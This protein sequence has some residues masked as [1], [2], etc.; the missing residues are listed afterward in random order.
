MKKKKIILDDILALNKD[1]IMNLINDYYDYHGYDNHIYYLD[2]F[3]EVLA[4]QPPIYI[5]LMIHKGSFTPT[6]EYFTFDGYGNIESVYPSI[7]LCKRI[8]T[9]E[10]LEFINNNIKEYKQ[11]F[12]TIKN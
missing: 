10:F 12:K 6:C 8:D 3:D 5:A 2:D 7:H 4:N 11:Y 9:K 1:V